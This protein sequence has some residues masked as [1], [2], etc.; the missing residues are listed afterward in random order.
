MAVERT[1]NSASWTEARY[2]GFIRSGLRKTSM[3]WPPIHKVLEIN[4]R[5]YKGRKK[6]VKWEY[7]CSHCDGWFM[8]KE[9][10]VHHSTPCGTL[11]KFSDL[12]EFCANLFCEVDG[13]EVVC[14]K[15]HVEEKHG[16]EKTS[17]RAVDGR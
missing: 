16:N 7:H 17:S 8:R 6:N 5:E 14:A 2:F 1:R 13:L 12:P 3:R 11:R 15:C 9:V 10:H 4:R